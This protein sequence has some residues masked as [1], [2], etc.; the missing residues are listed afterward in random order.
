MCSLHLTSD[1]TIYVFIVM[2]HGQ[3]QYVRQN[4]HAIRNIV[5]INVCQSFLIGALASDSQTA[6]DA[7][8]V[9]ISHQFSKNLSRKYTVISGLVLDNLSDSLHFDRFFKLFYTL[10]SIV[11]REL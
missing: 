2:L 3:P 8:S 11:F 4:E 7:C 1:D 10:F 5:C 9:C 6:S